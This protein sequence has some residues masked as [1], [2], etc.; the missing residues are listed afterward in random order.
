MAIFCR[1]QEEVSEVKPAQH[2]PLLSCYFLSLG[3]K[4]KNGQ[5]VIFQTH[6]IEFTLDSLLAL[7]AGSTFPFNM[8]YEQRTHFWL[9]MFLLGK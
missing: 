9:C 7:P 4:G 1:V 2:F 3:L 8:N 5:L 6:H